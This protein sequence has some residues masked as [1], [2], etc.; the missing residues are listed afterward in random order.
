LSCAFLW[1]TALAD[2][3]FLFFKGGF[4]M[5]GNLLSVE[6]LAGK[7]NVPK[8]WIYARTR[9]TDSGSIPRTR[10]GKYIRFDWEKVNEWIERQ[11]NND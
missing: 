11:N 7:L 3:P 8:S 1:T 10:L 6:E 9:Q 4:S 2:C 5:Q